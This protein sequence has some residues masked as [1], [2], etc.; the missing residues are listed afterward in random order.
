M[1]VTN[2]TRRTSL[3]LVLALAGLTLVLTGCTTTGYY[4]YHHDD[5]GYS[6]WDSYDYPYYRPWGYKYYYRHDRPNGYFYK[7][8]R[9]RSNWSNR[10]KAGRRGGGEPNHNDGINGRGSFGGFQGRKDYSERGGGG[11]FSVQ[12]AP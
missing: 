5:Y 11:S 8:Y 9:D 1:T 12:E 3:G 10:G 7:R 6:S 2:K 4:T